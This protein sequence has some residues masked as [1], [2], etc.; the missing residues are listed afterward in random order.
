MTIFVYN[1]N[2]KRNLTTE[3]NPP[4]NQVLLLEVVINQ[5]FFALINIFYL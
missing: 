2:N 5:L 4:G 1:L 3:F